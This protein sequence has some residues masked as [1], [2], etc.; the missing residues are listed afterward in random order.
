MSETLVEIKAKVDKI[1][2]DESKTI[3]RLSEEE[4]MDNFLDSINSLKRV[5]RKSA[6]AIRSADEFLSQVSWLEDITEKD[7]KQLAELIDG[8]LSAHRLLIISYVKI[9]RVLLQ[10]NIAKQELTDFKDAI[11]DFEE[12][13][14][15]LNQ[16]FFELRKDD[17]FNQLVNK[18]A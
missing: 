6:K 17:G 4:M 5:L 11:D 10:D 16:I 14:F 1:L 9:R 18:V 13:V 7:D 12:T 2:K 3:T 8:S 15:E